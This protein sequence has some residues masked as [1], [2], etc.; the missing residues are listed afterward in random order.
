M[1]LAVEEAVVLNEVTTTTAVR[2]RM[3]T[4]TR[5]VICMDAV[6]DAEVIKNHK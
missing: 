2:I 1:V 6:A 3:K 4:I 5:E